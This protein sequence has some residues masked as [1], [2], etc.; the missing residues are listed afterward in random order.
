MSIS[1][2]LIAAICAL[3][4]LTAPSV[5]HAVTLTLSDI[6]GFSMLSSS[7]MAT[8]TVNN[9]I[10]PAGTAVTISTIFSPPQTGLQTANVGLAG[11]NIAFDAGDV[12]ELFLENTNENPW[13]FQL[14]AVTDQGTF[15]STAQSLVPD[16]GA[17]FAAALGGVGG[18]ITSVFFIIS[19]N[20][21]FPDGDRTAEYQIS[22]SEIP[23]P[24]AL[25]LFGTA[26]LGY[27]G[28]FSRKR[29]AKTA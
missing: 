22:P 14:V 23:V 28:L 16:M 12:F 27:G 9:G 4:T 19:G 24:G 11:L 29:Y 25:I 21:P 3:F 20:V 15:M 1:R 10:I 18:T 13:T 6:A 5:G 26:L 17:L 8:V 2:N 7:N